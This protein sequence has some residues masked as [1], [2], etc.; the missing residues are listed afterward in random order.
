MVIDTDA[1]VSS[2]CRNRAY[3]HRVKEILHEGEFTFPMK[4]GSIVHNDPSEQARIMTEAQIV[5]GK[6]IDEFARLPEDVCFDESS[7]HDE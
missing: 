2:E 1:L 7:P 3:V 5:L 4:D 6:E